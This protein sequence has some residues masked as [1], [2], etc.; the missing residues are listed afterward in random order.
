MRISEVTM[1]S[2]NEKFEVIGEN[3]QPCWNIRFRG[4][5]VPCCVLCKATWGRTQYDTVTE[6]FLMYEVARHE[7]AGANVMDDEYRVQLKWSVVH[8]EK[9]CGSA[10]NH[11][12]LPR[13]KRTGALAGD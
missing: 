7:L 11:G 1:S 4:S 9:C 6:I 2:E 8:H 13:A 10:A 12:S 3:V 5:F